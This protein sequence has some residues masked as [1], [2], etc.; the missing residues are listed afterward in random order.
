[1]SES[2]HESELQEIRRLLRAADLRSTPARIQVLRELRRATSPITH[3]EL[4]EKLAPQGFDKATIFRNLADLTDVGILSRTELGDHV[5][6]FE[7]R[8]PDN[9][10]AAGHPHFLCVDCGSVTCL[11][12]VE[13]TE[14]SR[15][16]SGSIS[17]VTEI[18]I[19]GHCSDCDAPSKPKRGRRG[20]GASTD[21]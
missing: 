2:A 19:K 11:D 12:E 10:H 16:T 20:A 6:R 7:L 3:A 1:M 15:K 8:D 4:Y 5:W 18:L 21:Q 14:A 17:R 9:D 13:L